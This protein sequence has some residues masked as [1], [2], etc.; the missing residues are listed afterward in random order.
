MNDLTRLLRFSFCASIFVT[1]CSSSSSSSTTMSSGNGGASAGASGAGQGDTAASAGAG[2]SVGSGSSNDEPQI[3]SKYPG[4][5]GIDK[6]PAVVW[7]E[8]FE[9]G[10]VA[11][12]TARYDD[13]KNE[14]GMALVPDVP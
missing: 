4:D 11:A 10:S 8:N 6:D 5:V 9:E 3:A 14:A 1:A 12:V 7:V 2:T 13:K